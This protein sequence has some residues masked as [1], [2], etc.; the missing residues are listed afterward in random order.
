MKIS[1]KILWIPDTHRPYHDKRAWKLMIKAASEFKPDVIVHMGDLAD[2][3]SVSSH[4]KDPSRAANLKSE[5]K[6]VNKG[7]DELDALGAK[8][9]IFLGGNHE[10][11][12]ERYLQD[13][14]PELYGMIE[15]SQV[16]K[17]E[18]RGWDYFPYKEN[19]K[20]GKM[21]ATH[22]IGVATRY[23][24]YRA[25]ETFQANNIT[26]HTHRLAY[27]VEGDAT[28]EA[29]VSCSFGWLG[30]VEQCDYMHKVKAKRNWALGFGI[31]YRLPNNH[32]H[33]TPVPIV[34]Y[35]C[36]VEGKLYES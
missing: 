29:H 3:Y 13:K 19:T 32:V 15:I 17:L 34:K 24:I 6:D 36:V 33:V 1:E 18:E 31:G 25:A 35:K 10:Y 4:R 22:D 11:R 14:A 16:F 2:F 28:G 30:D 23:A 5:L 27:M 8:K 12:L 9:K 21:Y 7:L 20:I 26:A